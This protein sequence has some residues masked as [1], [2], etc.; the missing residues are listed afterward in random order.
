MVSF[1]RKVK[2]PRSR[3][4]KRPPLLKAIQKVCSLPLAWF[5]TLGIAVFFYFFGWFVLVW[6]GAAATIA[7]VIYYFYNLLRNNLARQHPSTF[8]IK[9][10]DQTCGFEGLDSSGRYCLACNEKVLRITPGKTSAMEI[11]AFASHSVVWSENPE[12]LKGW[13]HPG[14]YCPNGCVTIFRD[15]PMATQK[16]NTGIYDLCLLDPGRNRMNVVSY[17]RH[18]L[19][20]SLEH[21]KHRRSPSPTVVATGRR[22]EVNRIYQELKQLGA[23]VNLAKKNKDTP[24]ST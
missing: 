4:V 3:N 1:E 22:H 2:P 9:D 16:V 11:G 21:F 5:I 18:V 17:L 7:A 10:L 14:I 24:Q 12:A 6:V 13:M 19:D 23:R 20:V 15:Y 8:K